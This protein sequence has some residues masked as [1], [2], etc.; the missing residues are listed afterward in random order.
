MMIALV[1]EIWI[2]PESMYRPPE[3]MSTTPLRMCHLDCSN[4]P[5][6]WGGVDE[7]TRAPAA[8]H[9]LPASVGGP[10]RSVGAQSVSSL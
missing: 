9:A 6:T 7:L 2:T 4:H 10:D 1:R 8:G 5:L 3:S